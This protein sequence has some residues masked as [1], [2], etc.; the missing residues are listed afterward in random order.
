MTSPILRKLVPA[1]PDNCSL[2]PD[3]IGARYSAVICEMRANGAG[4]E[5]IGARLTQLFKRPVPLTNVQRHLAHLREVD[6]GSDQPEMAGPK[7]NDLEIIDSI[8][9]AGFRN[10]RNW[11]PTIR[12]T[13]DAM[14]LK[15]QMTGN[16]AFDDLIALFDSADDPEPEIENPEAVSDVPEDGLDAPEPDE[17]LGEPL[18]GE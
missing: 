13:L 18:E 14:K 3:V 4:R 12:D 5:K 1:C 6:E 8:I 15:V 16:S 7:P 9:S 2:R 11:K 10:S 17:P